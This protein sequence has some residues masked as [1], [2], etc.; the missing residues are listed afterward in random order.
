MANHTSVVQS[1][2]GQAWKQTFAGPPQQ[3][4]TLADRCFEA[5]RVGRAF[6]HVD[7]FRCALMSVRWALS[8]SADQIAVQT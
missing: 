6:G 2:A 8:S 1:F 7:F 5:R 4:E 3:N